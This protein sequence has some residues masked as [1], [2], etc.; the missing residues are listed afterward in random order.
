MSLLARFLTTTMRK[1]SLE[2]KKS[3][4]TFIIINHKK[5]NMDPY[6]ASNHTFS[7][8]NAYTHFLSANIYFEAVQ[9]KDAQILDEREQKIGHPLR[10]KIEKSKFGAYPRSCEFKVDFGKGIIDKHEEIAQLAL[11][12]EVVQKPTTVSHQYGDMKWVGF[13]KFCDA[14]KENNDL[15]KEIDQKID[16][17]RT[18]KLDEKRAAQQAKTAENTALAEETNKK[19]KKEATI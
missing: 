15:C 3:N 8:G 13:G 4:A 9:R 19:K 1:L 17:A 12:Y 11:N 2:L 14:L 5:D 10:A 6:A 18:A 16:E 7:G